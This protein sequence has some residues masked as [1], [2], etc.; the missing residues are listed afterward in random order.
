MLLIQ[1]RGGGQVRAV[2]GWSFSRVFFF[3]DD[4]NFHRN[5]WECVLLW[6]IAVLGVGI[7]KKWRTLA[8]I[9]SENSKNNEET[10]QKRTWIKFSKYRAV[11]KI[12]KFISESTDFENGIIV[13]CC[14][15]VWTLGPQKRQKGKT[16]DQQKVKTSRCLL[17]I[18]LVA[19]RF[20][21]Q[22]PY[23]F[24]GHQL[25]SEDVKIVASGSSN[26]DAIEGSSSPENLLRYILTGHCWNTW[27]LRRYL[28]PSQD[29]WMLLLLGLP[30]FLLNWRYS[31]DQTVTLWTKDH[32]LLHFYR[33]VRV[34]WPYDQ[35]SFIDVSMWLLD[36]HWHYF[37]VVLAKKSVVTS[38]CS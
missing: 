27:C 19:G 1:R 37:N 14:L 25:S 18:F 23:K 34:F 8:K 32:A 3:S 5:F 30:L 26:L 13:I 33:A 4:R 28:E 11:K 7:P 2:E 10:S 29:Q 12:P 22:F 15:S 16:I 31:E 9:V 35:I 36:I 21:P 6:E 38:T 17:G 20:C 24:A